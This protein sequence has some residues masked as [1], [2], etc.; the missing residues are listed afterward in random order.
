MGAVQAGEH[1]GRGLAGVGALVEPV[2]VLGA[3]ADVGAF[4]RV[5]D[6]GERGHGGEEEDLVAGVVLDEREELVEEG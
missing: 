2:H 5:D 1:G 6:S 3:G 4:E